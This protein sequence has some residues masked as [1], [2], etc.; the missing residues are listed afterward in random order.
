MNESYYTQQ[1]RLTHGI[2]TLRVTP[3]TQSKVTESKV[4]H[5]HTHAHTHTH[6]HSQVI[7]THLS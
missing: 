3:L 5:T 6:T 2:T 7:D 4:L 1:V